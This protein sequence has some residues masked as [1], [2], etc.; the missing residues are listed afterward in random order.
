MDIL[1]ASTRALASND[2]GDATYTS[3]ENQIAS[4]TTQRDALAG[5]IKSALSGAAF[6]GQAL[7]EQ[8]ATSLIA[9]A[10]SLIA[11]AHTLATA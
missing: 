10:T 1:K 11:Q 6:N 5:Q 7:S 8:Q 9:Q 3:I 4:L 2:S